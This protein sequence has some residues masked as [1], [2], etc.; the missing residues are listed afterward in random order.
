MLLYSFPAGLEDVSGYPA[1]F[2]ALGERGWSREDLQKL[3]GLNLIR[4]FKQVES[5][6][7]ALAAQL[8][9]DVPIPRADLLA[10]GHEFQC[11]SDFALS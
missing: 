9:D 6:R 7:D 8:P 4:V 10:T 11:R 2:D 1:L 3:A 5:V